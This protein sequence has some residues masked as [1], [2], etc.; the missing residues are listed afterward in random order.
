MEAFD[1]KQTQ[2]K[3]DLSDYTLKEAAG[4]ALFMI[5]KNCGLKMAC[6]KASVKYSYRPASKIE[7]E[8]RR[9]L[10]ENFF[11][12]RAKNFLKAN[13]KTTPEQAVLTSKM[14]QMEKQSLRH[15]KDIASD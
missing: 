14:R 6:K 3:L 10:P 2:A 12:R 9:V 11:E 1:L 13:F 7:R 4:F 15:I 8:V 5:S